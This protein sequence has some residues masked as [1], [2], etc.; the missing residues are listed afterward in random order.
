MM[1]KMIN[2]SQLI[3]FTVKN[4]YEGYKISILSEKK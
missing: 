4:L 1:E 2:K 3:K